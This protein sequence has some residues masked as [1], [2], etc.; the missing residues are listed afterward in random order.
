M[1]EL[2]KKLLIE[3]PRLPQHEAQNNEDRTYTVENPESQN[4]KFPK[5]KPLSKRSQSPYGIGP[6]LLRSI[7]S[8]DSRVMY[9]SDKGQFQR[10]TRGML[11]NGVN[12]GESE[13]EGNGKDDVRPN[14]QNIPRAL[15]RHN[16]FAR[17]LM[18]NHSAK[19]EALQ[20][21][22]FGDTIR[23]VRIMYINILNVPNRID[24]TGIF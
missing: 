22:P 23:E 2:M 10:I 7:R 12:K 21:H 18:T 16:G 1:K 9:G 11:S 3:I 24:E 20:N 14:L 17:L 5:V 19:D 4:L 13:L 15:K 6:E 8:S